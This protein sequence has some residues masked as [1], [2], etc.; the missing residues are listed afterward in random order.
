MNDVH[1]KKKD[2]GGEKQNACERDTK[3]DRRQKQ[4]DSSIHRGTKV[5]TMDERQN[6]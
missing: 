5:H 6:P 3:R 1:L 4:R 2:R